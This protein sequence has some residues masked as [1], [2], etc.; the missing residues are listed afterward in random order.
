M[1]KQLLSL[2]ITA[3]L[4]ASTVEEPPLKSPF[5]VH[6]DKHFSPHAG[7]PTLLSIY[8]G[9]KQGDER[10]L[11]FEKEGFWGQAMRLA[12]VSLVDIPLS[13]LAMVT[14]HEV[15]GHGYRFRSFGKD[16][17][18]VTAYD[19]GVP[20]PFGVG[21]GSTAFDVT[22]KF[23][24]A[25]FQTSVIGGV[26]AT[27]ILAH[28]LQMKW[29][30]NQSIQAHD[31]PLRSLAHHD[32]TNYALSLL[33]IDHEPGHDLSNYVSM[34]R[35]TYPKTKIRGSDLAALSL[36]NF[37]SPFDA[38]YWRGLWSYVMDGKK[39]TSFPML[40]IGPVHTLPAF[41]L[42]LAPH[43]P[44]IY[45]E[46]F[47]RIK[48][49]PIYT[50]LKG[51]MLGDHHYYGLGLEHPHMIKFGDHAFGLKGNFWH[52]PKLL[53]EPANICGSELFW[54]TDEPLGYSD[55]RL[56][57]KQLGGSLSAT[58]RYELGER[59]GIQLEAGHKL[60]GFLPGE[61][62]GS[63]PILRGALSYSY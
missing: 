9:I 15:F 10:Y 43:G 37:A 63:A 47:M 36:I 33:I 56:K 50:Y 27:G 24:P 42:G 11:S 38:L 31:L 8:E 28:D 40:K 41:R 22:D 49:K 29:L 60:A 32:L 44:E 26:E 58:Y 52:H 18:Q 4:S 46:N 20:P 25:H 30:T 48:D 61:A 55:E 45:L 16:V 34:L 54:F 51:G 53:T 62:M 2:A 1:K 12:H 14:Q 23:A 35:R 59:Y 7:S 19:I 13:Y 3:A 5:T 57:E 39:E 21:G 6:A 17:A